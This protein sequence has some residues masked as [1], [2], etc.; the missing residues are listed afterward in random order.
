MG[1]IPSLEMRTESEELAHTRAIS[2]IRMAQAMLSAP[3]RP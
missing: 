2:S 1:S 3:S